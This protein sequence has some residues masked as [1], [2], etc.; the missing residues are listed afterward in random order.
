[1]SP[2]TPTRTRIHTTEPGA[3][4]ARASG[5]VPQ[6]L[7]L[8]H[9]ASPAL[10][11][12]AFHFSQ[13]LEYAV[14]AGWVRDE[15]SALEWIGGIAQASLATLDLPVLYRLHA[16]WVLD[17]HESVLRWNAFLIACRETA[18]LRLEDRHLG[19]AL[20]RVL[21]ELELTSE[22][23]PATTAHAHAGVAHATAFAFACARWNIVP[24]DVLRTF[25]WTWAENQMLAA[26][27]LVPLGQS[28]G[29]RL[30]HALGTQIGTLCTRA[31]SLMDSDIGVS[32]SLQAVASG[33]HETQYTRLFRS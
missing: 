28:A 11:I 29:Q 19:A 13:G 17:D 4:A 30:L 1:M 31:V 3:A 22:L 2:P 27:K 18:E 9:L 8:L 24:L 12:G 26:V 16:A 25:A 6:L 20:L 21:A 14:E 33:R 15:R 32:S 7:R 10:P 23:F 5:E